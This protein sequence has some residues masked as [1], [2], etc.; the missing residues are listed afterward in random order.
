MKALAMRKVSMENGDYA[1]IECKGKNEKYTGWFLRTRVDGKIQY[2]NINN[3]DFMLSDTLFTNQNEENYILYYK[4]DALTVLKGFDFS[5]TTKEKILLT[6]MST[7]VKKEI[8]YLEKL[9]SY[10]EN[11]LTN[12]K[13]RL[14]ELKIKL[15]NIENG[16]IPKKQY[17]YGV[18][19][20]TDN[21]EYCWE[22]TK[23]LDLK[24]N[25]IIEVDTKYG[26]QR[27]IITKLEES[28]ED[29]GCKSIIRKVDK[30]P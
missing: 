26:T 25:D 17:V 22:N 29:R 8:E 15:H 19:A 7:S 6:N 10:A 16:I 27:A 5:S 4:V 12:N 20:L 14:E 1:W 24:E 13:N 11:D 18:H 23:G 30:L 28:I 21:R 2:V 9:I 3:T